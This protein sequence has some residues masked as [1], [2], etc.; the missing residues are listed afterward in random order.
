MLEA[1]SGFVIG[2]KATSRTTSVGV[3]APSNCRSGTGQTRPRFR[4]NHP[5]SPA[6]VVRPRE[7]R[8]KHEAITESSDRRRR[9]HV[10]DRG[11]WP[12]R[13]GRGCNTSPARAILQREPRAPP[14]DSKRRAHRSARSAGT[15]GAP[16]WQ[17]QQPP[18][19]YLGVQ[20]R[21]DGTSGP[22]RRA[23][24]RAATHSRVAVRA[25]PAVRRGAAVRIGKAD[26]GQA[27]EP[28]T[29]A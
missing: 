24:G 14:G 8:S 2:W 29:D 12:G 1:R 19:R 11:R 17:Q 27:H 15:F 23:W 25:G 7:P 13:L 6:M 10:R 28:S 5:R 20:P 26:A 3:D 18:L 22:R 9:N 4:R 21:P 16:W